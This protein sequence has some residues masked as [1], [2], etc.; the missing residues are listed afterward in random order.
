MKLVNV[1]QQMYFRNAVANA[2]V[3]VVV[4]RAHINAQ[5][6]A[7]P[8]INTQRINNMSGTGGK[9]SGGGGVGGGH[10]GGER[11]AQQRADDRSAA[12]NSQHHAYNPSS[13]LAGSAMA[14]RSQASM[15]ARAA[16]FNPQHAAFNPNTAGKK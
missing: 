8:P 4:H 7:L 9:G 16:S 3:L 6:V 11:S 5:A 13:E 12:F 14:S 1:E 2:A 10:H 15:D